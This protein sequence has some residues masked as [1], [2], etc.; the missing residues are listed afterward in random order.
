MSLAGQSARITVAWRENRPLSDSYRRTP[1]CDRRTRSEWADGRRLGPQKQ[2][3]DERARP[4]A[5]LELLAHAPRGSLPPAVAGSLT[6]R[7]MSA[8]CKCAVSLLVVPAE[9]EEKPEGGLSGEGAAGGGE[10]GLKG[11]AACAADVEAS[12]GN[13]GPAFPLDIDQ[14]VSVYVRLLGSWWHGQTCLLGFALGVEMS[15]LED[16]SDP[17][18]HERT[19][20]PLC[21]HHYARLCR[22]PNY[23]RIPSLLFQVNTSRA[24]S[25]RSWSVRTWYILYVW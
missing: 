14:E 22:C 17:S 9:D 4:A 7:E 16:V 6:P 5:L 15:P 12:V 19:R 23:G 8:A 3:P 1:R 21:P 11:G 25:S 18:K 2:V 10:D 13:G 24:R 20:L